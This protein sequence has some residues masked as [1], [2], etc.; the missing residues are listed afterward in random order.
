MYK[1]IAQDD[2]ESEE[3]QCGTCQDCQCQGQEYLL[4]QCKT[5]PPLDK[6]ASE[7]KSPAP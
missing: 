3:L 7:Q 1:D 2:V 5:L 4:L 6:T